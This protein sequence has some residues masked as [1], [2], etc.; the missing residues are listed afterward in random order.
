MIVVD[1]NILAYF[2]LNSDYQEQAE[3]LYE[4]DSDW[5]APYLWRSELRNILVNHQR[6]KLINLKQSKAIMSIALNLMKDKEFSPHSENVLELA[7]ESGCTAYDCEYAAT[8]IYLKT[9]LI[10]YDK[11]LLRA[12]PSRA[13]KI[14]DF[15][16]V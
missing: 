7:E 16:S 10:T 14:A 8:A 3:A 2:L 6:K 9:K 12:F 5:W 4:K 15:L 11:Q 1:S 13:I